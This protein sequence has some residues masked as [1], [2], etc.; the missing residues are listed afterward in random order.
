MNQAVAFMRTSSMHPGPPG[1]SW[2]RRVGRRGRRRV[3]LRLAARWRIGRPARAF[4]LE[5]LDHPICEIDRWFA[6]HDQRAE[7]GIPFLHD[8]RDLFLLGDLPHHLFDLFGEVAEQ[9]TL[10]GLDL[11]LEL[12]DRSEER[13]VGKSVDLGCR[14]IITNTETRRH[15]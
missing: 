15:Y 8:Q 2:R 12:L 14:R 1:S 11:P 5:G 7:S 9:L 4:A 3:A 10:L 13:R 6:V